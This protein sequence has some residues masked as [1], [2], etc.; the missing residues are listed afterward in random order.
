MDAARLLW[1]LVEP[2][3]AV[4]YFGQHVRQAYVDVGLTG[5]WRGYFAGRAAPMGAVEAGVVTAC[6]YGFHPDFVRRAIPDVWNRASP[7][8]AL[9]ARLEGVDR[10]MVDLGIAND[11]P[12]CSQAASQLRG[13]M[14]GCSAAGRPMFAANA[15]LD[16]PHEPHLV[17][18]QAATLL[19]EHRGDGHIAALLHAGVGPCEAHVLRI[20]VDGADPGTIR[21]HRGWSE[22]DWEAATDRLRSRGWLDEHARATALGRQQRA[23]IEARTDELAAGPVHNLGADVDR[24][25]ELMGDLT[26]R[27]LSSDLIPYPNAMGVPRPPTP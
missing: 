2:Y 11:G 22:D 20:A 4:V 13:A 9:A 18:W 10:T 27:L 21:P 26:S 15:E 6:F 16:W 1:T 3:H 5:F 12:A 25:V 24:L 7:G 23:E 19:R 8:Q 17:L 14:E